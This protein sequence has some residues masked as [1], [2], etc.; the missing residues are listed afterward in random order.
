MHVM[1]IS[2]VLIISMLTPASASARN[3]RAA[4]PGAPSMPVPTMESL[5]IP[6]ADE[7]RV[8]PTVLAAALTSF[9]AAF[10]SDSATENVRSV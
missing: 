6:P 7:T 10:K 9:S 8:A 4:M 2:D 1:R 5:A 3:I